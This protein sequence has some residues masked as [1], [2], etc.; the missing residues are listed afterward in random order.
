MKLVINNCFGGFSLS[1]KCTKRYLELCG[2]EAYFYKQTKYPYRDKIKEYERI[3]DIEHLGSMFITCATK[4]YGKIIH[5]FPDERFYHCDV[6]RSDPRLVQAVEELGSAANGDY[7]E[8]L[9]VE[10]ENGRYYKINEYDGLESIEYRDID[11]EWM[12][13][14]EVE[15]V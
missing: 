5:E 15:D 7:A 6:N 14:Q 4:D 11:D 3:D 9:I 13:A 1:P 8:L 10:I 2:K 12:L